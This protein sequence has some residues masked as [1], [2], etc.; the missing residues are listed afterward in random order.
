MHKGQGS[1][2]G[3]RLP[4]CFGGRACPGVPEQASPGPLQAVACPGRPSLRSGL[5]PYRP[6]LRSGLPPSPHGRALSAPAGSALPPGQGAGAACPWGCGGLF[7]FRLGEWGERLFVYSIAH[8]FGFCKGGFEIFLWGVFGVGCGAGGGQGRTPPA[9]A[10]PGRTPS[11]FAPGLSGQERIHL[12]RG[13]RLWCAPA[14]LRGSVAGGQEGACSS[15]CCPAGEDSFRLRSRP[16]GP[17]TNPPP[18]GRTP[19]VF[20]PG[21]SGQERIHLPRGGR[22]WCAPVELRGS[23]AGGQELRYARPPS[24]RKGSGC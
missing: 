9:A 4:F 15:R 21:L 23:V 3:W 16:F 20:A 2:H 10:P 1:C 24:P 8:V 14:E 11:V 12:P 18:S 5:G 6:S 19:S 22:L 17:G 13:G 7:P